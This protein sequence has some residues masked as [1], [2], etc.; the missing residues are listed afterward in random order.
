MCLKRAESGRKKPRSPAE[1]FCVSAKSDF[2][3]HRQIPPLWQYVGGLCQSF[4][5]GG[6]EDWSGWTSGGLGTLLVSLVECEAHSSSK[7]YFGSNPD[8]M[9]KHAEEQKAR[10]HAQT[11]Y[12]QIDVELVCVR[13]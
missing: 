7:C 9:L 1:L 11:C 8:S 2:I 6:R 10:Q 4:V 12:L 13:A 5:Q 3:S